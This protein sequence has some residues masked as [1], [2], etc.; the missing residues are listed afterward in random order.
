MIL[1]IPIYLFILFVTKNQ[2]PNFVVLI[3]PK[4]HTS[5]T[6]TNF[7]QIKQGPI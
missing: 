4:L 6:A 3:G 5:K 1:Q 2:K 7:N